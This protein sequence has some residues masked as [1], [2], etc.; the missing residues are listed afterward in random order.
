MSVSYTHLNN[1]VQN[2]QFKS[3]SKDFNLT[4]S[5]Q[6]QIHRDLREHKLDLNYNGLKNYIK[7]NYRNEKP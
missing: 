4:K 1:T 2:K 3:L 5:E 6:E 7:E